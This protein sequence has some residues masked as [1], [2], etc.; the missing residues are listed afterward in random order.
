MSCFSDIAMSLNLYSPRHSDIYLPL[1][2]ISIC[3]VT[4]TPIT[5][6]LLL[7][8]MSLS[9]Y[10]PSHVKTTHNAMLAPI[11]YVIFSFIR[12]VIL[13]SIRHGHID[14]YSPWS[15]DIY[16]PCHTL[17]SCA[18]VLQATFAQMALGRP[19]SLPPPCTGAT[20]PLGR[21]QS[22]LPPETPLLSHSQAE[23]TI[24]PDSSTPELYY[25]PHKPGTHE[26]KDRAGVENTPRGNADSI[27]PGS[28]TPQPYHTPHKPGTHEC[29]DNKGLGNTPIGSSEAKFSAVGATADGEQES[30]HLASR[31][32]EAVEEE[33]E[34]E[35]DAGGLEGEVVHL[36]HE[37]AEKDAQLQSTWR[38]CQQVASADPACAYLRKSVTLALQI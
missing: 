36:R 26:C 4:V 25:S 34:P 19:A 15:F 1:N 13:A 12:H 5:M 31:D 33:G 38:D 16:S 24:T 37:I 3:N 14:S 9:L 32:E 18:Q 8:A 6:S 29:K 28:S 22:E 27:T 23:D 7:L 11:R 30:R 2:I 10:F 21:A 17:T 35:E 20:S